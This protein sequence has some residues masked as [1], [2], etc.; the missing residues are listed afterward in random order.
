MN[1]TIPQSVIDEAE[2]DDPAAAASEFGAQFRSDIASFVD[3]EIVTACVDGGVRERPF[4][5]GT[6][7]SAFVD[8][9]GGSS[10]SMTLAIAHKEGEIHVL[11]VIREIPAPFDPESAT[12]EFVKML[13]AY[14]L[15]SVRGDRYAAQWVSQSFERHGIRY[16]LS[17]LNRSEI[18]LEFLPALNSKRVRLLDNARLV[19]QIAGLE[20][21]TSRGGKDSVDHSPG[22]KDD[23]ANCC[24]GVVATSSVGVSKSGS[25]PLFAA[26]AQGVNEAQMA[27]DL[28]RSQGR[29]Y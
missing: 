24:A 10:D 18:Y 20:R 6:R 11:D 16:E 19:N 21:R 22:G 13:K 4:A 23:V 9:S 26:F 12:A 3:R 8:P 1:P 7:Y 28:A 27:R 29:Y 17:Q 5:S 14:G 2:A 25:M 15:T